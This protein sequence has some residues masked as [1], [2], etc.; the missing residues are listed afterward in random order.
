MNQTKG[1]FTKID[2]VI[3]RVGKLA[4]AQA[5]Y[6]QKLGFRPSYIGE[7]ERLVVFN[8]GGE[9]P[10][11]IYELKPGEMTEPQ[12]TASSYPIFY[13]DD[14]QAAHELLSARGVEVGPIEGEPD[15]T[16]WFA[17]KDCDGNQL[18]VCHYR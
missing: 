8:V 2:T 6:E 5:W 11:T 16:Q 1:I 17:F 15:G 14:I 12:S 10:L 9:T 7:Q 4:E 13:A 18:E 3:V